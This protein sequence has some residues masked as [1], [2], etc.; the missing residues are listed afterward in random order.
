MDI[1]QKFSSIT[2]YPVTCEEL[3][4]GR[5]D[6]EIVKAFF[7][8]GAT[9]VQYR[10]KDPQ[11]SPEEHLRVLWK[12][13]RISLTYQSLLIVNDFIELARAVRADGVHLGQS[14]MPCKEA[15]RLLGPDFIIGISCHCLED[16]LKAQKDGATYVNIGPVF[17]T[18]TKKISGSLVSLSLVKEALD[19]LDIPMTVMG[20]ISFRNIDQVL[21]CGVQ[22][23]A[24][25]TALTQKEDV[26][27]ETR[28]YMKKISKFFS[29]P[30]GL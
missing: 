4:C 16:A 6:E 22:R 20:G 1:F 23:I 9:I 26:A 25:V 28:R 19:V 15:R 18:K 10:N 27:Q 2:V 7:E 12:L 17:Q 8:G 30:K 5:S 3:S 11:R 13:R 21:E 14:D 24:M 29:R